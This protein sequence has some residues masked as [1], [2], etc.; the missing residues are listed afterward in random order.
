MNSMRAVREVSQVAPLPRTVAAVGKCRRNPLAIPVVPACAAF[1]WGALSLTAFGQAMVGLVGGITRDSSSGKPVAEVQVTAHNLNKG[2]DRATVSN[3]DGSFTFTN[4]EPGSY[5]FEATKDG[6]RKSSARADVDHLRA[7][8]VELPLQL[9]SDLSR[10]AEK[11]NNAPLTE[12]EREM[13][14]RIERLERRIAALDA[15]LIS[16]DASG[17]QMIGKTPTGNV[18]SVESIKLVAA[19]TADAVPRPDPLAPS[20]PQPGVGKAPETQ[21]LVASLNLAAAIPATAPS[22]ESSQATS[23]VKTSPPQQSSGKSGP[24]AKPPTPVAPPEHRLPDA[25]Q[26][27]EAAPSVDNQTP[28]AF[29][30]FSWLNGSAR[31]KDT[32]LDTKFFTPEVRFDTHYMTDFNQPIDHTIV[33]STESFRSG[34]VQIEQASIGGDFHWENVRGRILFIE[35]L[36]ATTTPRNDASSATF[37]GIGNTGGVG[38]WDLQ[39]A[40]KY[41]SEAYGGYHFNVQHGLNVD[42]GIFVSYIGLF[43]YYNFDN[44]TYQPS[45]VSSNT[46]WFF[47]GVRMQ[48][49]PTNKLK[50]EPW[51]INGW[52]SYAKF[53]GH[54]G[55]GGQLLWLP[56]E[57]FKL[58]ANQY[59]YGQDNLGLPKTQRIHTDDSIEVRYYNNPE[60]TGLSKMAFSL[61]GDAGCQYGGGITCHGG[62][63]R[64]SFVGWMLYD[65]MWFHKDLFGL[66]LGGGDMSNYGRYLT[67]LPPIDGAWAASGTPY[68][69][70]NPGQKA[71]MWDST[72]TL[73][74]MPRQYITWWAE[75]GYRHSDVPYFAGRGGVTPPGGN[76]G[77]PQYYTCSSGA[78]AGTANLAAA[79]A[80]CGGGLGSVW[81]PDLRRS[82]AKVSLGVMV[83]F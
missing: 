79:E 23:P 60:S 2:T 71:H 27:P 51:F 65:R 17:T 15:A 41:V 35:G 47:N 59:G 43:S 14:E 42:A 19:T 69:T 57:W 12:R 50:I 66:T 11:S 5:E 49:F 64:S 37:S 61:T 20:L 63:N 80:A 9:A 6:F 25:L 10:T 56:K 45:Y 55:L 46:P 75:V 62:P 39:N 30:D 83:K 77:F 1:F 78:T 32:V 31:T 36:F 52:Q 4:L 22:S 8:R 33:G 70:E 24:V 73:Q 26:A 54:P 38:Q 29:G 44:W 53:N 3:T 21:P 82:E 34:E 68:F 40:Y 48:W 13:L 72:V 74:Y 16:K 76:N 28:F 18:P 7:A 81:F 58:V 67:L